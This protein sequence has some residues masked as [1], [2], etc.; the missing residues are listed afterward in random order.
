MI[1]VFKTNVE[2]GDHA[3]LLIDEIKK[4][5]NDYEVNFDLDDCDSILRVKSSVVIQTASLIELLQ[6]LGFEASVLPDEIPTL[7]EAASSKEGA[8]L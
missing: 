4:L 6:H 2:H 3:R 5:H 1:E 7:N 8:L